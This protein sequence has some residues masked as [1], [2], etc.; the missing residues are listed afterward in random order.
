MPSRFRSN[1]GP[2][3]ARTFVP[4]GSSGWMLPPAGA[5]GSIPF[6]VYVYVDA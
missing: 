2:G 1:P 5:G 3:M 4:R 6:Y